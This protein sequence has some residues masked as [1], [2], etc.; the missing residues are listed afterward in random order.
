M[1]V[2]ELRRA[3]ARR[4][5]CVC[6]C[7]S[8][9]SQFRWRANAREQERRGVSPPWFVKRRFGRR[10]DSRSTP[11]ATRVVAA[12]PLQRRPPTR[13]ETLSGDF[14]EVFLQVR[15]PNHGGLTPAAL[16]ACAFV[17]RKSRNSVGGRKAREQERGGASPP[18]L[19]G[20]DCNGVRQRTGDSLPNN[21]GSACASTSPEPRRSDAHRC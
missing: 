2:V 12:T 4:S 3:Y 13:R 6:V 16:G 9:K 11:T 19:H 18:W 7:A 17:H 14:A 20:R 1:C 8:Q 5:C 15:L 10:F 21:C